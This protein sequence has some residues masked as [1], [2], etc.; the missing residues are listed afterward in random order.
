[1]SRALAALLLLLAAGPYA[2]AKRPNVL[3]AIA[4]DQS[5]AHTSAAG[6]P[7][8]KTPAFDRVAKEGVLF[9]NGFAAAPGCNPSRAALLT[10]RHI[11]QLG[12]AGTHASGFP[13]TLP[14]YPDVLEKAGYHVGYT[15][16][17]WGPG[18][19][20]VGGRTRN[21]AGPVFNSRK[22][23]PPRKGISA[24]D[25][26]GNFEEFLKG[27]PAGKP[28]CFWFGCQEPH[29][30]YDKG[31]GLKAGKKLADGAPP[32]FLPDDPEVR[33]DLLDYCLE[34]EWFDSHLAKMLRKLEA[35][36]ELDNTLVIVT[37]DNGMSFPRAKANLYEYG[38]HVPLAA[39]WGKHGKP[40][41]VVDDLVGF[42]DLTATILDVAGVK[43]P[44][45]MPQQGRSVK[46]ILTSEKA[47][48]VDATRAAVYAGRE[49]HSCSRWN[50]LGYP[51]RAIRTPGYLLIRNFRPERWPAGDPVVLGPGDRPLGPHS[52]YKDIDACPTL[53]LMIAKAGDAKMR[54]FLGLAVAKR[55]AVELFDVR[56]D[57]ACLKD[58]AGDAKYARVRDG[59]LK[60][61]ES[62]LRATKDSRVDGKGEEWESYKRYGPMR[63]FPAPAEK[64][65]P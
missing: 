42:V 2:E 10:G 21:P 3:L 35:M 54:R 19:F 28:F 62:K 16:K 30:V 20:K 60:Q 32:A 53:S 18:N 61:L 55:P 43:P 25:Y 22:L 52:G 9:R 34:V 45:D 1:M 7:G 5:F 12:E 56:A 17:G 39:R 50:N 8:V 41:R 33:S 37:A 65:G 47:G 31:S 23:K 14:T 40:G 29:R 64:K 63:K 59:L 24:V 13:A 58:L 44:K 48:T 27:R 26:A 15:G 51:Q 38:F 36:G 4:D 49:R 46:E 6:Y 11:W 57:P